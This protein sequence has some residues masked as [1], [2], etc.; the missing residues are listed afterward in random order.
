M[1]AVSTQVLERD[2]SPVERIR[3][4]TTTATIDVVALV[5]NNETPLT[6]SAIF[7]FKKLR[8][9]LIFIALKILF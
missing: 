2:S 1:P 4:T 3:I 8:M 5:V 9:G 7:S 6:F